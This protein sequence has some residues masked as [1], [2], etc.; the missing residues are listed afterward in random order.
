MTTLQN[1]V[2]GRGKIFLNQFTSAHPGGIGELY[3]GNTPEFSL[4]KAQTKLDHFNSDV[5][6]KTKDKTAILTDETTGKFTTDNIVAA[7]LALW[8]G[9]VKSALTQLTGTAVTETISVI[10]GRSYQIGTSTTNVSGLRNLAAFGAKILTVTYDPANYDIDLKLGRLYIHDDA[11]TIG[12][13]P[14]SPT[15]LILTYDVTAGARDLVIADGQ[16]V[17]GALRFIA[18]NAEGYNH[19]Y[20]LP[21]VQLMANGDYALKGDTWQQLS[22]S[23]DVLKLN[24]ATDY[25]YIDG[26]AG[27]F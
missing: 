17:R 18:D 26:R 27:S 23:L 21:L 9:G 24:D 8:F 5:R 7:N 1:Q 15:A 10:R 16:T 11:A 14:A 2:L 25:V 6:L 13:D 12:D 20:F 22:F 4:A 19:D 3:L